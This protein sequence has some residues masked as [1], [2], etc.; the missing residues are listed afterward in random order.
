M[1]RSLKEQ[2]AERRKRVGSLKTATDITREMALLYKEARRGD[3][4]TRHLARYGQFLNIM[5]NSV[6]TIDLEQRIQALE[7]TIPTGR[8][9]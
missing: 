8:N 5:L 2:C 4:E 6:R 3:L 9:R 1:A 7:S